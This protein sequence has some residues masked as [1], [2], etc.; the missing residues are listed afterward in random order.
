MKKILFAL[1]VL[2]LS[3][4]AAG[5]HVKLECAPIDMR[6][7]VSIQRGARVFVNYCLTCHSAQYMRYS[8]LLA[9]GLSEQQVRDNVFLICLDRPFGSALHLRAATNRDEPFASATAIH[10]D[11]GGRV[12]DVRAVALRENILVAWTIDTSEGF[13]LRTALVA[14]DG[15]VLS[16]TLE[17]TPAPKV[18]RFHLVSE[19]EKA[20]LM[21]VTERQIDQSRYRHDVVL[22]PRLPSPRQ[23]RPS[24]WARQ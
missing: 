10:I 13:Q 9:L 19:G 14:A 4:F 17:V 15:R 20:W 5:G 1:L 7:A 2:P 21:Y 11:A 22:L 8:G 16:A 24:T 3:A 12:F 23:R 6:D 18:P